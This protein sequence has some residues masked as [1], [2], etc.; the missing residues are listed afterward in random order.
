MSTHSL[1][2]LNHDYVTAIEKDPEGFV[3]ALVAHMRLPGGPR[4]E[5]LQDYHVVSFGV[6]HHSDPFSVKWGYNPEAEYGGYFS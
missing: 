3:K 4:T 6:R 2:S 1:I 5:A